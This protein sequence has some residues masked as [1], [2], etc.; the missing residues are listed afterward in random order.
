MTTDANM[1]ALELPGSALVAPAVGQ[2]YMTESDAQT[3]RRALNVIRT[4]R[5]E[6]KSSDSQVARKATNRLGDVLCYVAGFLDAKGVGAG[7]NP[8]FQGVFQS[9]LVAVADPEQQLDE[10]ERSLA[11]ALQPSETRFLNILIGGALILIGIGLK[12]L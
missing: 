1:T 6:A 11:A 2:P 7:L 10:L 4:A 3:L 12:Q 5:S 8:G 9:S